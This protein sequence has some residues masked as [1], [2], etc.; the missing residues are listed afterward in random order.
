MKHTHPII[1]VPGSEGYEQVTV[2]GQPSYGVVGLLA[3]FALLAAGAGA[4]NASTIAS[5]P[6]YGSGFESASGYAAGNLDAQDGWVV[7]SGSANVW[8]T[9]VY[10]GTQA[11]QIQSGGSVTHQF[12]TS[13][14]NVT[15]TTYMQAVSSP[16]PSIPPTANA[17]LL[18]LD[19]NTG[20][21]CLNGDGNGNGT[22]V[23]SGITPAAGAWFRLDIVLDYSRKTWSCFVNGAAAGSGLNFQSTNIT[24]LGSMTV[25][26][27][28][29]G[30][31]LLDEASVAGVYT[32]PYPVLNVGHQGSQVLL[33]WP[34]SFSGFTVQQSP[35][36]I[37]P[38][39][40]TL[41]STHNQAVDASGISPHFYRLVGSY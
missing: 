9:T 33:S 1:F 38:A 26:A 32:G 35:S 5:L 15:V 7:N 20:I 30:P 41:P 18:Y 36:L 3:A 29:S 16:A 4:A 17:A 28:G 8:T 37:N 24:G 14:S 34:A 11:A 2:R 40:T 10:S 12:G 39:W 25:S 31:T 13:S 6:V 27:P 21:T 22:W 19:A 23:G